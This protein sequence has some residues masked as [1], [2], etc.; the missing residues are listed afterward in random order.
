MI[1]P[2]SKHILKPLALIKEDGS[3]KYNNRLFDNYL[4]SEYAEKGM[5]LDTV[6]KILDSGQQVTEDL[7]RH[8]FPSILKAVHS[9]HEKGFAH[10][11]ITHEKIFLDS[12]NQAMLAIGDCA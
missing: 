4:V 1:N 5:L 10:L 2:D 8:W 3:F 11:D 7:A 12:N 6:I 9:I